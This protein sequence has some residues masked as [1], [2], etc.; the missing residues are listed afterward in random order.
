VGLAFVRPALV[1]CSVILPLLF[2]S[3]LTGLR[4]Y[5]EHAATDASVLGSARSRTHP[6][7]VAVY[8]GNCLHLEHHLYPAVPCYRL[9]RVRRWLIQQGF[10]PAEG[11]G[12]EPRWLGGYRWASA[13]FPYG[14]PVTRRSRG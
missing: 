10:F 12:A 14:P 7:L 8:V 5:L 4:P 1:L 9:A 3:L 11:A 13:A 2:A 6:W